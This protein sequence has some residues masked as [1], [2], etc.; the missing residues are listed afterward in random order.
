[1][2]ITCARAPSGLAFANPTTGENSQQVLTV[3][4]YVPIRST[5]PS[6]AGQTVQLY[7]R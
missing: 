2:G 3:Y 5:V 7:V 4:H 6:I 1:V